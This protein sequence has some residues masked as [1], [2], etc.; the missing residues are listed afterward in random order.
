MCSKK[1]WKNF[2]KSSKQ[3]EL[4]KKNSFLNLKISENLKTI[5]DLKTTNAVLKFNNEYAKSEI[6]WL[7]NKI[8]RIKIEKNTCLESRCDCTDLLKVIN[9]QITDFVN[10][11]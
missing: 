5:T 2:W 6:K 8:D 7:E 4:E 9:E 3:K 11:K 1:L 10:L